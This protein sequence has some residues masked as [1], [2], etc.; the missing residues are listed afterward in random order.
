MTAPG[1]RVRSPFGAHLRSWRRGEDITQEALGKRLHIS[2]SLVAALELGTRKPA[3]D[4]L[5]ALR[6]MGL[7]KLPGRVAVA[8]TRPRRVVTRG[9]ELPGTDEDT[10][11]A[12]WGAR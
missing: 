3:P 6:E 10:P 4:V 12:Q 2:D 1:P 11:L 7:P 5:A 8:E 9:L